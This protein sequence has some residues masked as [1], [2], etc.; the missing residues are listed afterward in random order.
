MLDLNAVRR[1]ISFQRE[2]ER[3]PFH[4]S[5]ACA[6]VSLKLAITEIRVNGPR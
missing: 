5:F 1:D 6:A 2:G 3:L 4:L